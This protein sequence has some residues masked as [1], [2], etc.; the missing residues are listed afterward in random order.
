M[1]IVQRYYS[2]VSLFSDTFQPPFHMPCG[3]YIILMLRLD[4]DIG[5]QEIELGSIPN[6]L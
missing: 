4:V 1:D 5:G 3:L 6:Q 2:R